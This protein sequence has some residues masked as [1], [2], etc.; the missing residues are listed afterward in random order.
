LLGSVFLSSALEGLIFT[1]R[2]VPLVVLLGFGGLGMG[3][4]FRSLMGHLTATV[5]RDLASDLSGVVSTTSEVAAAL[6]WRSLERSTSPAQA[7]DRP[8]L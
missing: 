5:R 4:G 1:P 3:A 6:G 7:G 8:A 2:G